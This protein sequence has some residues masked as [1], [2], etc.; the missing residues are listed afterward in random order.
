[1]HD[2]G[3]VNELIKGLRKYNDDLV[4]LCSWE[5]QLQMNRALPTF[6]LPQST[7]SFDLQFM[8]DTAKDAAKDKSSP[9]ADGRQRMAVM[10]RFKARVVTPDQLAPKF[11]H[12]Q[13]LLDQ[14]DY[15][16]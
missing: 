11:R 6:A 12:S 9:M 4:R 15:V 2:K 13:T 14:K 5:A 10:A 1:M 8:A 16:V 3:H 7:N